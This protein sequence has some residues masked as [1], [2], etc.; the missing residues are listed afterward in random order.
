MDTSELEELMEIYG[1]AVYGFCHKLAKDKADADDLYQETF[2]KAVELCQKIN[3]DRNPKGFLI[4]IAA[5]LWKN[6]RRKNARRNQIAPAEERCDELSAAD[7]PGDGP[8][9]EEIVISRECR[10]LIQTA[11]NELKEKLKIPLYMYYTAEMSIDEIAQALK[12]PKGT[13]KSRLYK[14]R[15]EL[16]QVLEDF[17]YE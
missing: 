7:M 6:N 9:P 17:W 10:S 4:S 1:K 3:R 16:E 12:I 8:T 13:V 5:G 2:L 15:K 14:A 11:T